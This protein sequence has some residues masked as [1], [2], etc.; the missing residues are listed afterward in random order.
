MDRLAAQLRCI[1]SIQG[2]EKIIS[3]DPVFVARQ[4]N[5]WVR[6]KKADGATAIIRK[7]AN[8]TCSVEPVKPE[9]WQIGER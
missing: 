5:S 2:G 7:G 1:P 4:S 9:S 6:Y 8:K 3:L